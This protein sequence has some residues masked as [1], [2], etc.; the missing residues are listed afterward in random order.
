MKNYSQKNPRW[1]WQKLG[2]CAHT[3]I[4]SDGCFV[5][6]LASLADTTIVNPKGVTVAC[7][8]GILDW[9]ATVQDLYAH[10]CWVVSKDFANLLGLKYHGKSQTQ[11]DY[12]CILETNY[13]ANKGVPQHFVVLFP[14]GDIIDS[15][16][17]TVLNGYKAPKKENKYEDAV[18]SYRLFENTDDRCSEKLDA[19]QK[20]QE[21]LEDAQA[22]Y[23][24]CIN[25]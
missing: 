22:E 20:A 1:R 17:G 2:T 24:K 6:A 5:N 4:G 19:V 15:L 23:I 3:T 8:P 18:V 13:Y 25:S 16:D 9:V 21:E 12:P 11:P 7:H 10:G 14:D